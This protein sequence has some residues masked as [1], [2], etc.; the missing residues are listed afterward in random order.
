M[1]PM[2]LPKNIAGYLK[3]PTADGQEDSLGPNPEEALSL[4]SFHFLGKRLFLRSFISQEVRQEERGLQTSCF[5]HF[6]LLS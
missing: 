5:S 6:Y 4:C 2:F 3:V 1:G